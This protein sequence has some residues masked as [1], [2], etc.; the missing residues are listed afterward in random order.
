MT[1]DESGLPNVVGLLPCAPASEF[2]TRTTGD[3]PCRIT[4]PH[5]AVAATI[6]AAKTNRAVEH[7]RIGPFS[8]LDDA[9]GDENQQLLVGGRVDVALEQPAQE[10]HRAEP[11][12]A[13]LLHL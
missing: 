1:S 3:C 11:R 12:R 13:I 4:S 9:R 7:I 10:R 5:E 2:M 6:A 8:A